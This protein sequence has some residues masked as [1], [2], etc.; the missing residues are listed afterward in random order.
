MT[1]SATPHR[2][3]VWHEKKTYIRNILHHQQTEQPRS[4]RPGTEP[5]S[6]FLRTQNNPLSPVSN[7]P[8]TSERTKTEARRRPSREE[9]DGA[10]HSLAPN[11][12]RTTRSLEMTDQEPTTQNCSF[13]QA[14]ERRLSLQEQLPNHL[15]R[16]SNLRGTDKEQPRAQSLRRPHRES[17]PTMH[18]KQDRERCHAQTAHRTNR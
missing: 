10:P 13:S 1:N 16:A 9:R 7:C 15:D 17:R 18:R 2:I 12:E 6:K 8:K 5:R 14:R 11:S 4:E 3:D